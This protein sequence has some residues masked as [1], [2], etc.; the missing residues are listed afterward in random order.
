MNIIYI[1]KGVIMEED[2]FNLSKEKAMDKLNYAIKNNLVDNEIMYIVN[3]INKLDNYYTTSSCIGRCGIMEF[4]KDKNPKINSKWTGKWHHY[5][6]KEDLLEGIKNLSDSYHMAVFVMNSPIL[7]VACKNS[8]Y[9]KKLLDLAIHT[10][11]KASSVK[12]ISK[13]RYIVEILTTYKID[14]PIG[15]NGKLMVNFDYLHFLLNVGNEKLK[16]SRELLYK[17]YLKL[18]TL[19]I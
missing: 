7:H 12:S 11:L 10:G 3:K 16:K 1:I 5:A 15:Y 18:D 19:E 6:S 4:P 17:L 14:T 2:K 13:N 8:E 9:A